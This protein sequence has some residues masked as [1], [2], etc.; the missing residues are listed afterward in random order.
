MCACLC[1]CLCVYVHVLI[2]P[3]PV[4]VIQYKHTVAQIPQDECVC[5]LSQRLTEAEEGEGGHL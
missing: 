2:A 5:V 1:V 3:E 4:F